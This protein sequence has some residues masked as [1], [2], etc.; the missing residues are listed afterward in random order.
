MPL[1]T[2]INR[3]IIFMNRGI[4]LI[5]PVPVVLQNLQIIICQIVL[6]LQVLADD[7]FHQGTDHFAGLKVT[8]A[9]EVPGVYILLIE[10]E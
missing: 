1:S 4:D 3:L 6:R 2:V 10:L 7:P 8:Q 5:Q 9:Q